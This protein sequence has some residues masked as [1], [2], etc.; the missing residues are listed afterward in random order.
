MATTAPTL[1][2]CTHP[3]EKW[4]NQQNGKHSS[5]QTEIRLTVTNPELY[6]LPECIPIMVQLMYD[7]AAPVENQSIMQ[8]MGSKPA[9]RRPQKSVTTVNA[10]RATIMTGIVRIRINE[11]SKNHHN[12]R[13]R[14]CLTVDLMSSSGLEPTILSVATKPV[15]VLSK[16]ARRKRKR[17]ADAV[18]GIMC[19]PMLDHS[20]DL[21]A[22]SLLSMY[23]YKYI[24]CAFSTPLDDLHLLSSVST[25]SANG[26]LYTGLDPSKPILQC[27]V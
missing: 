25:S 19:R 18:A 11:V 5:F 16:N 12:Q 13:F 9:L 4:Y 23:Q 26:Q 14:L 6:E 27:I 10:S 8:L 3:P 17:H 15:L 22:L 7:G 2:V 21:Q 20:T 24:G 1:V